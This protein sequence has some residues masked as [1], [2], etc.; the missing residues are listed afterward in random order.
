MTKSLKMSDATQQ[1]RTSKQKLMPDPQTPQPSSVLPA[2]DPNANPTPPA[3]NP[4]PA[5]PEPATPRGLNDSGLRFVEGPGIEQWMVGKTASEVA[6]LAKDLYGALQRNEPARTA[7]PSAPAPAA[8]AGVDPNLV[9]TDAAEFTRQLRESIRAEMRQEIGN[10]AGGITTPLAS[11]ARSEASRNPRYKAAWGRW[12]PEIDLIMQRVPEGQ[13]GRVDL[14]NEAA[15]MVQGEHAEEI[16]E[17]R[18]REILAAGNDPGMLPSQG[19][20][21]GRSPSSALSPIEK[22]FSE[23][24]PAIKGFKTD[25]INA[26]AVI[27]HGAK[28]GHSEESYAKML[29][30]R[31]SRS[32]RPQPIA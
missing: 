31:A 11:L 16:A 23:D 1:K 9:Y 10:A 25:G 24:H 8:P 3:S 30:D 12:E 22:L 15:R 7:T 2:G 27:R 13:R 5:A 26:S 28:M 17:T 20:P 19:V 21:G 29:V 14:W 4:S 6:A 18:A 32:R